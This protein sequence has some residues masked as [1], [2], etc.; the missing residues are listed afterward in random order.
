MVVKQIKQRQLGAWHPGGVERVIGRGGI[1]ACGGGV[2]LGCEGG[3][4]GM[5]TAYSY[6]NQESKFET[7][8]PTCSYFSCV[9]I[10]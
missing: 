9:Q 8:Q 7:L 3:N 6:P 2:L 4:G 10:F 5:N 1:N